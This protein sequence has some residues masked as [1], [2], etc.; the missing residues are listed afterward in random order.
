MPSW[1][2][3]TTRRVLS[4][5]YSAWVG[6]TGLLSE[7][8]DAQLRDVIEASPAGMLVVDGDGRIVLINAEIERI[9]GYGRG[10]L[11]G[12]PVELL[13][14]ASARQAHARRRLSFTREPKRRPMGDGRALHGVRKDG[15]EVSL[16]IGLNPFH[17]RSGD[18]VIAS[19]IDVGDRLRSEAE[20][21]RR[22]AQVRALNTELEQR[23]EQRTAALRAALSEQQGRERWFS[24][25][26]RSIADAV[27]S[28]DCDCSTRHRR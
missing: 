14:P 13:L 1:F 17:D 3:V 7:N 25:T 4:A 22:L 12:H 8:G 19:V 28:V 9:F 23:V 6:R 2:D 5:A 26:M 21:E 11:V 16:E 20:R 15:R 27:V 18:P 24:T 10:E